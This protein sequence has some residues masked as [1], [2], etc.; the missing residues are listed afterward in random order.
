[1]HEPVLLREAIESLHINSQDWYIDAT[2]GAG[3]HTIEILQKGGNVLGIDQDPSMLEIAKSNIEEALLARPVP[4]SNFGDYKL[5]HGN[6]TQIDSLAAKS[7]IQKFSGVLLD[8]G[9][10]NVHYEQKVRGFSFSDPEAPLDMRL[11]PNSQGVTAADLL[12][13]LREDQLR[14]LF[15]VALDFPEARRL[16]RR[17]VSER[18]KQ[19]LTKIANVLALSGAKV[20]SIHPATKILMALRIAVNSEL[21]NIKIVLP[22]ALQLLVPGGRLAVITFHSTEDGLVKHIFKNLEAENQAR[23]ITKKPIVPSLDELSKNQKARSA[24][25]RVIEKL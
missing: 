11:D 19:P 6:F 22:K 5:L 16:A 15:Q 14:E 24:K 21:E 18:A 7:G 8:L 4:K 20:G 13:G 3:G 17:I 9:I 10:S 1:M 23:A 12:N 2:L 25:L